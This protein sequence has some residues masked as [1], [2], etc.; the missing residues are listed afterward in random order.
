MTKVLFWPKFGVSK[1]LMLASPRTSLTRYELRSDKDLE[2]A[3]LTTV[4]EAPLLVSPT[5]LALA[6]VRAHFPPS[7][8]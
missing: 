3:R 1:K 7:A 2:R 8:V 4:E 6:L 5:P